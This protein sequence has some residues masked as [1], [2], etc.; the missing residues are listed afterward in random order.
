[1]HPSRGFIK[2][3]HNKGTQRWEQVFIIKLAGVH[4]DHTQSAATVFLDL[5][6]THRH[7]ALLR[8]VVAYHVPTEL[9][10][11]FSTKEAEAFVADQTAPF[12]QRVDVHLWKVD[13]GLETKATAT[14]DA[15][16]LFQ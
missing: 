10:V 14:N 8:A 4:P 9:A 16:K 11:E 6:N 13:E 5:S 7:V 2:S 15:V 12:K 3:L 1:M